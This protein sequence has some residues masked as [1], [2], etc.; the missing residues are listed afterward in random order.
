MFNMQIDGIAIRETWK[1]TVLLF[2]KEVVGRVEVAHL[3]PEVIE[4]VTEAAI[5]A[6]DTGKMKWF[7]DCNMMIPGGNG[8]Q[9]TTLYSLQEKM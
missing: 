5:I 4:V 1:V 3:I 8:S 9:G 2:W 7:R 6:G